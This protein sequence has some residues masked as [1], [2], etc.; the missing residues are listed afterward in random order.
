M[1]DF[2]YFIRTYIHI[3][4]SRIGNIMKKNEFST[5]EHLPRHIRM[6]LIVKKKNNNGIR[7]IKRMSK[8]FIYFDK[9]IRV[10]VFVGC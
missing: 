10:N 1:R 7:I 2:Q 9:I 8:Y 5:Y 4:S 3:L 6:Y